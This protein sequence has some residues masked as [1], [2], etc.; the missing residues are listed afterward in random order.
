MINTLWAMTT[1]PLATKLLSPTG[2]ALAGLCILLPFGS[3]SCGQ[4]ATHAT[5]TYTGIQLVKGSGGSVTLTPPDLSSY[6]DKQALAGLATSYLRYTDVNGLRT[7]LVAT[8]G[9]VLIGVAT[10]ALRPALARV[11]AAA[12]IALTAVVLL[13]GAVFAGRREVITWLVDHP[14]ARDP[15]D[16]LGT[17]GGLPAGLSIRPAI[18]VWTSLALLALVGALN[19]VAIFTATR[20]PSSGGN[21]DPVTSQPI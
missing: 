6:A 16:S 3:V 9:T 11:T 5:L 18:G 10:A 4:G 21:V 17:V 15:S 12:A 2:F 20:P 8:L 14:A 13:L 7:L 19:T 1:G